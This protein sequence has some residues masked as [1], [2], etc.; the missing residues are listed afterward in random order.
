MLSLSTDCAKF[1]D[2]VLRLTNTCFDDWYF[3]LSLNLSN[4][5]LY[6]LVPLDQAL[7]PLELITYNR[8]ECWCS[9]EYKAHSV[10]G[11]MF[12]RLV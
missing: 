9:P 4:S 8:F 3:S 12:P 2:L 7:N 5:L 1:Y 10:I 11:L 6:I